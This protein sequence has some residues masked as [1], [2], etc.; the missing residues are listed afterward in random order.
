MV[1]VQKRVNC[2]SNEIK[3][4]FVNKEIAHYVAKERLCCEP[5]V[6]CLEGMRQKLNYKQHIRITNKIK[7]EKKEGRLGEGSR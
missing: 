6:L 4:L 2:I 5:Q 1:S 3:S 7:K